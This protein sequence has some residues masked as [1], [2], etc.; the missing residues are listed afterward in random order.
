MLFPLIVAIRDVT[1]LMFVRGY[2]LSVTG[3]PAAHPERYRPS[4]RWL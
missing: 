4:D 2:P 1:V 3:L